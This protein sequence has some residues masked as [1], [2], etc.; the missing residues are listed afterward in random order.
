[1]KCK[2]TALLLLTTFAVV[3]GFSQLSG[4]KNIPGDYATLA[5]AITALNTS[6]V[7]AGGVTLNLLSGN[8]QTAPAGGYVIGGSGSLVLTTTSSAKQVIVRGNGNTI[9][10]PAPQMSGNLNDAI[11]KIIGGDFITI[12]GFA[13][14][15]NSAN[16]IAA[17]GTNNMTE[18]GVALFYASTT[19]GAQNCTIQNNTITLNRTYQNTFGI[20]SNVRHSATAVTTAADIASSS[21]SNSNLLV[22]GNTIANVN[23]G[24][25]IVG[26]LQGDYMD[27]GL[28]IGGTNASTGN[29]I[30]NYGTTG[31]FSGYV[32]VSASVNGILVNNQLGFKISHNSITSSNGG[33]TGAYT[34]RGIY[35]QATGTIP[36]SGWFPNTISGNTISVRSGATSSHIL[37]IANDIGNA[38]T[39]L[40]ITD[41][42]FCNTTHSGASSGPITFILNLA[43][44]ARLLIGGN[45]F[46]NL[47]VT[48]T[49]SVTFISDNVTITGNRNE[50]SDNSIVTAFS[51]T[52]E[53]GA[54]TFLTTSAS[55][56][57]GTERL[58][59]RNNF[60]NVTVV[61]ATTV[62]GFVITDG[63]SNSDGP[64]QQIFENI[65]SNISGGGAITGI[66]IGGG[67]SD[68]LWANF[69]HSLV[70]SG[71]YSVTGIRIVGGNSK[72]I[73]MN[74][75]CNLEANNTGGTV[76]GILLSTPPTTADIF[77]NLIG[78]LRAPVS[79]ATD[80]IRGVSC[81]ATA[82]STTLNISF[83]TI[84]LN[85]SSSGA[86]FGTTGL[87][88]AA[89]ATATRSTLNLVDNIIVNM[90]LAHGNGKTVAY[91]R[92]S[93][94]LTNYGSTSN[95]NLF[96]AGIP[97]ASNLIFYDGTNSDQT[98]A[99]F[100]TRVSPREDASVTENPH[101]LSTVGSDPNF[102]HI[103][104]YA[105]TQ[106][107]NGGIPM[108]DITYDCDGEDRNAT[109]PDIGAD[110]FVPIPDAGAPI[111]ATVV[112]DNTTLNTDE[113]GNGTDDYVKNSDNVAITANITDDNPIT[114]ADIVADLGG[115]YGGA[116]HSSEHPVSYSAP[117]ATWNVSGAVCSPANET[118]TVTVSA[119]DVALNVGTGSGNIIADNVA[120]QPPTDFKAFTASNSGHGK[121]NLSWTVGNDD[122]YRGVVPRFALWSYPEYVSTSEPAFPATVLQGESVTTSPLTGT[123]YVH[124]VSPRAIYKYTAFSVDWAGNASTAA[125]VAQQDLS[126]N[127]FLG[128]L[129]SGDG[130]HLPGTGGYDGHV[131][132]VDLAWFSSLYFTTAASWNGTN[133]G[134]E[135]DFAPTVANKT[136]VVYNSLA[137]PDP[138]GVINFEDLMVFAINYMN[139]VPKITV[140]ADRQ[141]AQ[142]LAVELMKSS[143]NDMLT[144]TV[145][146]ANDGRAIKG[147]ATTLNFDPA[148]L[149][150][151]DVV[152]GGLFG[153][154]QQGLVLAK[155]ENNKLQIDA[156]VLGIDRTIDF[157]GTLAVARFRILGAGQGDVTIDRAIVRNGEN[158]EEIP[159]LNNNARPLP[160][161]FNL[162]QNYPNPFNPTTR[163]D[164][165]VPA[166]SLVTVDVYN[167]L[168]ER[169][170][171]LVNE[172][173]EQGYYTVVWDG[174]NASN[175]QVASGLYFYTM[176]AGEFRNV[177]KMMSVR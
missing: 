152:P 16:T 94:T 174:R 59:M 28:D 153:S 53:G 95:N 170:V 88:H 136:Y 3:S 40:I 5:E 44:T 120:P 127:Y 176:R 134:A 27:S 12:T 164:Y 8:P 57:S 2:A 157:S 169:V 173:K 150:F 109:T 9:T 106:I 60:S 49:G 160:T 90:S 41:N 21:G 70:T 36:T 123:T 93:T 80:A 77:D 47:S 171:T 111:V 137:I 107:E 125:T 110:E 35:A 175:Q 162:A 177:N 103:N 50:V 43:P 131:A 65:I 15:E 6:G 58:I 34:E 75:I 141:I 39:V 144:V 61:G 166:T 64:H 19:N 159:V 1:M 133:N 42:D 17:A 99:S 121:V 52:G 156:A 96:Y 158:N 76:N 139:T 54:L 14:T 114:T 143:T 11:F 87:Y 112:I 13:M 168:G 25:V 30:D 66:T 69:I 129:G 83:N 29:V 79:N 86:D 67:S 18:F 85:A 56:P 74:R 105:P 113:D 23:M 51:K 20:Y 155:A 26:S 78:D 37:G 97:S 81:P 71:P 68:E 163:I 89:S 102:L 82:A 33:V 148:Q 84:Y 98:L 119:T 115:F 91:R 172:V 73:G 138:D 63:V 101:F 122:H 149:Q 62:E 142:Q 132:F 117:V 24:I 154:E 130:E 147:V 146:V 38:T 45:T 4:T 126:T 104:P 92:S 22:Y 145:R 135:A 100:K 116:G 140:P 165:Q 72:M 108:A 10:A 32:S 128:D 118:I 48:T 151:V 167:V 46:S 31:S 161:V 55:S 7:G 124:A